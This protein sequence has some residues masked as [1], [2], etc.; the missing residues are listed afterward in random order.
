[1][2]ADELTYPATVKE[3]VLLGREPMVEFSQDGRVDATAVAAD[4]ADEKLRDITRV[5]GAG[6]CN[7]VG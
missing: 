1:M 6:V 3:M 5:G 2:I 7:D 4:E